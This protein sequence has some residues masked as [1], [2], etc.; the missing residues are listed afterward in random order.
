MWLFWE[1][2]YKQAML[3]PTMTKEDLCEGSKKDSTFKKSVNV[4]Y[5]IN[6]L[7]RKTI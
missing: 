2:G 5:H 3:V 6:W 4:I 1:E 7:E